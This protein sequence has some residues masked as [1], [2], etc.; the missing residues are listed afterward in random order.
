MYQTLRTSGEAPSNI[1]NISNPP[2]RQFA[3]RVVIA[4]SQTWKRDPK[5][6]RYAPWRRRASQPVEIV[7]WCS[8]DY[9]GMGLGM[10][11]HPLVV[12]TMASSARPPW[13]RGGGT[14]NIAGNSH[15]VVE[16][17][18]EIAD[19]HRKSSALVFSSGYV[20]NE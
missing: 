18:A 12:E 20:A 2:S 16:P 17:E 19:L 3:A 14:R 5:R 6:P 9:L 4:S 1:A 8:N 7:I 10:G 15:A 13:T 11:R